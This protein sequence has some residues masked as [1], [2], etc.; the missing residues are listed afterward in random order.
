MSKSKEALKDIAES[1]RDSA[2]KVTLSKHLV[3]HL[4]KVVEDSDEE[5][6]I[7]RFGNGGAEVA[8]ADLCRLV[9]E[10]LPKEEKPNGDR[11]TVK[12]GNSTPEEEE[13]LE[14]PEEGQE[15]LP[16]RTRRRKAKSE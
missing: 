16:A 13:E 7:S 1:V 12:L 11:K 5:I 10:P 15:T 2:G 3:R 6:T 8:C 9:L 14:T 4:A